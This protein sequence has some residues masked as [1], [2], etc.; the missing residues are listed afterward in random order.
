MDLYQGHRAWEL[1][2]FDEARAAFARA[3]GH[4][5][6]RGWLLLGLMHAR[7]E[8]APPDHAQAARCYEQAH[9]RGSA[10]AARALA[11]LYAQGAGVSQDFSRAR[12]L[13]AHAAGLGDLEA[14]HMLGVMNARGEGGEPD[15][16]VAARWWGEAARLGHPTSMLYL[17]HMYLHGDG[18]PA[19]PLRAARFY[20]DAALAGEPD[21]A[22][23]LGE[24]HDDLLALSAPSSPSAG[25]AC[26]LLG[27]CRDVGLDEDPL[28]AEL[29]YKRAVSLDHR[30]ARLGLAGLLRRRQAD[31]GEV[32]RLYAEAA[33]AGDA[34]AQHNLGFMH[35]RGVGVEKDL[36]RALGWFREAAKQGLAYAQ[37]DLAILLWTLERDEADRDEGR[38]WL[39]LAAK[40]GLGAAMLWLGQEV[41]EDEEA[42]RWL[43]CALDGGVEGAEEA[44]RARL[45]RMSPQARLR[46]ERAS[47]CLGAKAARLLLAMV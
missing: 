42:A 28:Q 1:G 4:G 2:A 20:L 13:Y 24:L 16:M 46:A 26:Y 44:L 36:G 29:F 34:Q 15:F 47:G 19:D 31:A 39:E 32:A 35:A 45:P 40:Q 27:R 12:D 7:G 18:L 10:A 3:A 17:G 30:A 33:Q 5:D 22:S 38:A 23:H 41:E 9:E 21:A 37:L 11:A 14:K 8:G 25:E 43:F 6:P